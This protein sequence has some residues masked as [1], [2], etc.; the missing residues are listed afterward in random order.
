[1]VRRLLYL[2]GLATLNVV[3]Y[4]AT[5]WVYISMFWWAHRYAEVISPD[6]TRLGGFPYFVVRTI[7]QTIIFTI[8]S[9]IFISG[10]FI[11]AATGKTQETISW[12]VILKRVKNLVIPYVFW[13]ILLFVS[14]FVI[15]NEK[16]NA[17]E[18]LR[19]IFTGGAADP[20]YFI[21]LL[22]QLYLLSPWIVRAARSKP[23][24][25]LALT[26][27][28]QVAVLALQYTDILNASYP[29]LDAFD[30][31]TQ[32]WF[33]PGHIFWFVFGIVAGFN[34]SKVRDFAIRFR[35]L[36]LATAAALLLLGIYEWEFLRINSGQDWI[37]P[38]E[39]VLDNFYALAFLLTFIAFEKIKYPFN[40][41][42]S[43]LGAKSFGI[44]LSHA[45]IL[46]YT[47]RAFYHFAP[48]VFLYPLLFLLIL[49]FVGLAIPLTAMA[50]TLKSPLKRIYVYV[51]G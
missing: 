32:S 17:T 4:H 51:F 21:P 41:Q 36:W 28:A 24:L 18:Y 3:I 44:Y 5:A 34:I 7:E 49:I 46:E 38:K 22:V 30:F 6:F 39:T 29:L 16:Y 13:S 35:W 37:G 27:L 42:I 43:N 23:W 47:A 25:L 15:N 8:P 26:G 1:M 48:A 20:F 19:R 10:F 45:P 33:F 14:D 2:N 40:N 31:L 12:Q 50:V 11:A 9:F